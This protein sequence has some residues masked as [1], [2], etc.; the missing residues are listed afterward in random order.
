ME[1]LK[2]ENIRKTNLND[3]SNSQK[4]TKNNINY[5]Q[6]FNSI[7]NQNLN[8]NNPNFVNHQINKTNL[9]NN[10]QYF[11]PMVF[12]NINGNNFNQQNF[13]QIIE[14]NNSSRN[15][16]PPTD[17]IVRKAAIYSQDSVKYKLVTFENKKGDDSIKNKKFKV[18]ESQILT[19]SK[20]ILGNIVIQRILEYRDEEILNKNMI[21]LSQI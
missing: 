5:N 15:E 21:L 17:E 10:H 4:S 20:D 19:L 7:T 8:I 9:T 13:N 16:V 1:Q 18:L 6:E 2:S 11:V 3:Y 12:P 14:E